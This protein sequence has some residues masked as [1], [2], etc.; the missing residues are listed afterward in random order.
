MYTF[1]NGRT[2]FPSAY[3]GEPLPALQSPRTVFSTSTTAKASHKF[4][5][6]FMQRHSPYLVCWTTHGWTDATASWQ[7]ATTLTMATII[8]DSSS[9]RTSLYLTSCCHRQRNWEAGRPTASLNHFYVIASFRERLGRRLGCPRRHGRALVASWFQ[10][11]AS[12]RLFV[13]VPTLP[14]LPRC[15]GDDLVM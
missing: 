9:A 11:N 14:W 13:M 10:V 7:L 1:W 8:S 2:N 12:E 4:S 15:F 3:L 5:W 6:L